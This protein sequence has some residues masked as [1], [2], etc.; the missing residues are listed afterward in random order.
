MFPCGRLPN[1]RTKQV[2]SVARYIHSKMTD[3]AFPGGKLRD[4]SDSDVVR[5]R[6]TRKKLPCARDS[7]QKKHSEECNETHDLKPSE[8]HVDGLVGELNQEHEVAQEG[9]AAPIDLV[10]VSKSVDRGEETTVQPTSSLQNKVGH[11]RRHIGLSGGRLDILQN[12]G[13]V[14]LRYQLETKDAVLG[15]VHVGC[16]DTGVG[17][18]H[19]LT[20]EVLLQGAL[21]RLV[22]LQGEVPVG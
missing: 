10:P 1:A 5:I 8:N 17:T 12:P 11:F 19:L 21:T 22:V 7:Q 6:K 15:K 13:T 2:T 16:E 9:M 14:A 20:Q 18:V 4:E 3:R